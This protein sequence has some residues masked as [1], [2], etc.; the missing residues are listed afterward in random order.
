[1][2]RH[3]SVVLHGLVVPNLWVQGK[4]VEIEQLFIGKGN[5]PSRCRTLGVVGVGLDATLDGITH[6]HLLVRQPGVLI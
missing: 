4:G 6:D 3:H 5:P 2:R 1:M